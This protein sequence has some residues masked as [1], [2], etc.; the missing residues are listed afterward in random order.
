M[1]SRLRGRHLAGLVSGIVLISTA[2]STIPSIHVLAAAASTQ[3]C[4]N[5]PH[6]QAT[7]VSATV[8][9][10]SSW[11]IASWET[12]LTD[13]HQS[14]IN[15][16]IL[17]ASATNPA[18]SASLTRLYGSGAATDVPKNLLAAADHVG[19]FA[20]YLGLQTEDGWSN[21]I[22]SGWANGAA[23]VSVQVATAI[24]ADV[25]PSPSLRGWYLAPEPTSAVVATIA[26]Q[27]AFTTYLSQTA[28]QLHAI[29]PGSKVMLAPSF[30]TFVPAGQFTSLMNA[31]ALSGVDIVAV[32]DQ[33]GA[34]YEGT[35]DN[36]PALGYWFG[37]ARSAVTAATNA[38]G[39]SVALWSG[40]E[41]DRTADWTPAATSEVVQAMTAEAPYVAG[42]AAFSFV[43]YMSIDGWF[44]A[45]DVPYRVY[46]Q[47]GALPT[48]APGATKPTLSVAGFDVSLSWPAAV[49]QPASG[50]LPAINQYLVYRTQSGG[51][52]ML[53]AT[54]RA[55]QTATTCPGGLPYCFFD[56]QL[57]PGATYSYTV[58][59]M[60]APGNVSSATLS[61]VIPPVVAGASDLALGV[62]HTAT[63]APS[64]SYPE[65]NGSLDDGVVGP[66]NDQ[67]PAWVGWLT[68]NPTITL[69]LGQVQPVTEIDSAWLQQLSASVVLPASVTY[70][71]SRD[72]VTWTSTPRP[73]LLPTVGT[74]NQVATYRA[75]SAVGTT[76]RWVRLTAH[77]AGAWVF[78]SEI[79]VHGPDPLGGRTGYVV[80]RPPS[81]AY[82]DSGGRLT[83]GRS[84]SQGLP[85]D[86]AWVGWR[87]PNGLSLTTVMS[88]ARLVRTVTVN[89]LASFPSWG[90]AVPSGLAVAVSSNGAT[91]RTVAT[92]LSTNPTTGNLVAVL[93]SPS[94]ARFVRVTV[95]GAAN[96][97]TMISEVT[98]G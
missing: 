39:R 36:P 4:T 80:S 64:S 72:G 97:W 77:D 66:A 67:D 41:T 22:T 3:S 57:Q 21:Q 19:G 26:Q 52:P 53:V 11:S 87:D 59:A 33:T 71:T 35:D 62:A 34:P 69:D 43:H 13:L 86:P 65:L 83:D 88:S 29:L 98:V 1:R 40:V 90:V 47:S 68:Q 60:N 30:D 74:G 81:P 78:A 85:S 45:Y 2:L 7:F 92:T 55:S 51:T 95:S 73:A 84:G 28:A 18:G 12:E 44:P 24:L 91:Y 48:Y 96:S 42:F 6:L 94:T 10:V 37:L 89:S 16:V 70:Q 58:Q 14:C 8:V 63:P 31:I 23:S 46:A 50:Y 32:Q 25:G 5:R 15:T 76:A 82:P 38:S 9:P 27:T 49:D 54:V 56:P 20:V 75:G 93:A 17:M 61:A 79:T